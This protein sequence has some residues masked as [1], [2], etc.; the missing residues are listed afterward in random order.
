MR[1]YAKEILLGNLQDQFRRLHSYA[2]K[3]LHTN[4]GLIVIIASQEQIF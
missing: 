2:A 4:V 1:R 3:I